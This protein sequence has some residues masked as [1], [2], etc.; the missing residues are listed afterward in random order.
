[1]VDGPQDI[2][3]ANPVGER[4]RAAREAKGM[5]LDDVASMTRVPIRHLQH[6]EKGEWDSLPAI[7]YSVGFARSYAKAVGLNGSEIGSE[8][9]AQLG[10]G[11]NNPAASSYE[12]TDPARVPPR[13]LAIVA[14]LIAI[15]LIG[16]YFVWRG[17][18]LGPVDP[19]TEA[20]A[21]DQPIG[22][23]AAPKAAAGP[24]PGAAPAAAGGPVVLTAMDDVWIS[25]SQAGG[26]SLF[27]NTL[28]RGE[29]YEVP[30]T[31]Q[32]AQL[33]VGRPEAL[34]VSVGGRPVAQVGPSGRPIGNVSLAPADLLA[35]GQNASAA[36]AAPGAQRP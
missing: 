35:R 14:A 32:G 23:E 26:P 29:R 31:A 30:A 34:A 22:P 24:Q 11:Y 16:G 17:N 15:L 33:R 25:V 2:L 7:T 20:A 27:Q 18:T 10:G 12:P 19:E 5:S 3:A 21:F 13:T 1:M 9:R 4:L 28:K 8:L 36:P 6:I